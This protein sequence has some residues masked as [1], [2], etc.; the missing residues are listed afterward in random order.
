MTWR[1]F[2]VE[3]PV[4]RQYARILARRASGLC[5]RCPSGRLD[6]NPKTGQPF[7]LCAACRERKN[8]QRSPWHHGVRL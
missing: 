2:S 6:V 4:S 5:S 1:T 8:I 7:A 3:Q